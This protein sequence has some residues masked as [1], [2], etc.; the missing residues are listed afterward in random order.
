MTTRR[1]YPTRNA[2][3]LLELLIVV[4][5]IA[6]LAAITTLVGSAVLD[7]G[8]KRATLGVLQSLD[9]ALAAYKD[10]NGDNPPA[11]VEI[12]YERMVDPIGGIGPDESIYYPAIDGRGRENTSDQLYQVNSVALF[13]E[14]VRSVP[15]TQGIVNSINARFVRNYSP[16]ETYFP[17]LVTVFDA[18]DNPIRYVH[19]KFDGIIDQSDR[20][21]GDAGAPVNIV[22]P[23]KPFFVPGALPLNATTVV[24]MKFVRR[25]RLVD[26]DFGDDG[27]SG[28]G[29]LNL[30]GISDFELVPDSD[31]GITAG[32]RPYF[33]SAGPDGNP[34][35][36]ED[37]IYLAPVQHA[38]PGVN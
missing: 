5:I 12:P 19:P 1:T 32:N 33:Y 23:N 34:A 13:I 17:Q 36:L 2:F 25:N 21:L 30:G 37:N 18:W 16:D 8:K 24:R 20:T 26:A 14:S 38:D 3:T 27:L 28:G 9:Q 4:A 29:G 10:K 22:N 15:E 6:G 31:G 7:S 11:L 35:T